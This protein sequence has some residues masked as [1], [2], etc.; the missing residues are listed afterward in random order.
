[1]AFQPESFTTGSQALYT[2]SARSHT[3]FVR[4][5]E[6]P[7]GEYSPSLSQFSVESSPYRS[8]DPVTPTPRPLTDVVRAPPQSSTIPLRSDSLTLP[9]GNQDHTRNVL[10]PLAVTL[11]TSDTGSFE[12]LGNFYL[13][14][15]EY[16]DSWMGWW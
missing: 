10:H 3:S 7:V 11:L 16:H 14:T 5:H 4:F 1:M 6:S 8:E 15:E 2:S 12:I 9:P 13:Y